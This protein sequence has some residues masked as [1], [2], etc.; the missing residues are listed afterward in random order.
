MASNQI[1][2]T[3]TLFKNLKIFVSQRVPSRHTFLQAIVDNGGEKALLEKN[4]DI[5]I[6]DHLKK[7]L[8]PPGSYSYKWLEQCI[9]EGDL[10]DTEPHRIGPVRG[11]SR[12]VAA[13]R[14]AKQTKTPYTA[15]DDHLLYEWVMKR[16]RQG[17]KSLG[18]EMYKALE[19]E[20]CISSSRYCTSLLT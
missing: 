1:D 10:V 15:E 12:P 6:A 3:E 16:Q 5:V 19:Q 8:A 20:V 2:G 14:P 4:A 7:D 18:N 17:D 13:G 11:E 9:S